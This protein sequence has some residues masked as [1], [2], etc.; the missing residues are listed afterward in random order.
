MEAAQPFSMT[1]ISN[2][3]QRLSTSH[4]PREV[5]TNA[6]LAPKISNRARKLFMRA[7]QVSVML[8]RRERKDPSEK[9]RAAMKRLSMAQLQRRLTQA[10]NH[11]RRFKALLALTDS[12]RFRQPLE[13]RI[14][15]LQ[16]CQGWLR[17]EAASRVFL[18]EETIDSIG[19]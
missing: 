18:T 3:V 17:E 4:I 1:K 8:P 14:T 7:R 19:N 16:Y 13:Q 9:V 6:L 15:W 11:L 10:K 12:E 5:A 2:S